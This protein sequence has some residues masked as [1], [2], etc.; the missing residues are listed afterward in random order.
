MASILIIDDEP[1]IRRLL[2]V[3][4]ESEHHRVLEAGDGTLGLHEVAR[5][6]PD[7]VILDLG[8]PGMGGLDVLKRIRE[9]S[10]V[11]VLIL[12]VREDEE[13]KVSALDAGADDYVNKPFGGAELLAR[14]RVLLRRVGEGTVE[15]PVHECGPLRVDLAGHRVWV[16]G[17]EVALT[18]TEFALLAVLVRHEGR[19]VTQRQLL[20][21]V[22]GPR[23]EEHSH[24]L[25]VYFTHVR[26][27]IDPDGLGLIRTE[28]RVGYRLVT[29][30][31]GL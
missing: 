12:S 29:P 25:R 6:R 9:W 7:A 16:A 10:R 4:L 18:A 14:L 24:Y 31:D 5:A 27:K 19:V 17:R 23:A 11:P 26:K 3:L 8:L 1:Q 15:T 13:D 21:E 20:R 2:R 28:P 30:G 22:W